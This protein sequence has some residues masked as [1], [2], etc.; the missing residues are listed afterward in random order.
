MNR[1]HTPVRILLHLIAGLCMFISSAT[2]AAVQKSPVPIPSLDQGINLSMLAPLFVADA[3]EKEQVPEQTDILDSL[4]DSDDGEK[5]QK[6]CMT[7]CEKW[8]E[9]CVINPRTGTRKCRRTCK[10]LTQE[11][12]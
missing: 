2:F 11:C 8:G 10:K 1:L 5:T 7:V 6:K 3:S 9:D 12:F 4:N